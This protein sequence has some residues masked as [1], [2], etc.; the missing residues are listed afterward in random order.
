MQVGA[1]C[2]AGGPD[3]ANGLTL[4]DALAGAD[5]ACKFRQMQILGDELFA[6][7]DYDVVAV[8]LGARRLF[9]LAVACGEYWRASGCSIINTSVWSNGFVKRVF[10]A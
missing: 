7:F 4:F 8:S 2:I 3:I 1:S 10:A 9:N 6:V 5:T